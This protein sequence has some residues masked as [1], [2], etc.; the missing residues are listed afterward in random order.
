MHETIIVKGVA[1]DLRKKV[2]VVSRDG[3][4]LGRFDR[5]WKAYDFIHRTTSFSV[6]WATRYEGYSIKEEV[7]QK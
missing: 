5:E 6:S 3:K 1:V 7:V 2:W 4:E